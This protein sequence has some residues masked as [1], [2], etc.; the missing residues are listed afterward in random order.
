MDALS[1]ESVPVSWETQE[2]DGSVHVPTSDVVYTAIVLQGTKPASGDWHQGTWFPTAVNGR[3][4]SLL[5]IGPTAASDVVLVSGL[6]YDV[7][8]KLTDSPDSPVKY[9]GVIV[10]T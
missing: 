3:Y 2:W 8:G 4:I 6:R 1:L 9:A 10:V 7:Y 5:Q